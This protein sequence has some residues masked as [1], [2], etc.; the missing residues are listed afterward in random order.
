MSHELCKQQQ[1]NRL[2]TLFSQSESTLC[3]SALYILVFA[4]MSLWGQG[5]VDEWWPLMWT[6]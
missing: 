4:D 3:L 1:Q 5:L 2:A 6:V